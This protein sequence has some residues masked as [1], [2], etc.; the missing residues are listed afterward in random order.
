MTIDERIYA[1][2]K[3]MQKYRIDAYILSSQ[4]PH[5]T[6]NAASHYQVRQWISGFTGTAGT[7]VITKDKARIWVD[8]RYYIQAE[9][10]TSNSEF[11]V[12]RAGLPDTPTQNEWILRNLSQGD[13]VALDGMVFS[14]QSCRN[15][16]RQFTPKGIRLRRGVDLIDNIWSERPG[17]PD[18]K[19]KDHPL[20]YAGQ[21]REDKLAEI[22]KVLFKLHADIHLVCKLDDIAWTLNIRGN[23]IE[24]QPLATSFL[25]ISQDKTIWFINPDKVPAKLADDIKSAGVDIE[26]YSE[27]AISLREIQAGK[28]IL[29]VPGDISQTLFDA[30]PRQ[31]RVIE[32][33]SPI[34]LMKSCKNDVEVEGAFEACARDG[35]AMVRF[36]IWL[37]ESVGGKEV[38]EILCAEK[39][40]EFR[41]KMELFQD[42]SFNSIVGYQE[43][44]ALCHYSATEKSNSKIKQKGLLLIDSGGHYLDGT[45][46]MTRTI[47]VGPLTEEQ[48]VDYTLVLKAH[49]NLALAIFPEGTC[50]GDLEVLAK[51]PLWQ[52][53]RQYL[54]SA[55]HGIGSY[56][57]VHEGPA[58]F[59]RS[60]VSLQEGMILTNEPGLYREGKH[61]IRIENMVTVSLCDETEFGIFFEL[62]TMGMCPI[63]LTPVIPEL[64]SDTEIEWLN[65]YHEDVQCV[66]EPYLNEREI[67]WLKKATAALPQQ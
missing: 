64:L 47:A 50:G 63:D 20:K 12:F 4:D 16:E 27:I 7:V 62:E 11:K 40:A 24:H 41:S 31:C 22:K 37:E 49:I 57:M 13:T 53:G 39:V 43:H 59:G 30:I 18:A 25:L 61:G 35:A 66:L 58:G 48:K 33:K 5:Q 10:E 54:H 46:D 29:I 38:T 51:I 19:V 21:S 15:F 14:L 28:R 23:D 42:I 36:L 65:F 1:L 6:E 44:A 2:R 17:L 8:A 60:N 3:E 32:G 67:D 55:G 56:L 9:D 52:A 34:P 45:T 26:K